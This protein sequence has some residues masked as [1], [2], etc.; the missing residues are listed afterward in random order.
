MNYDDWKTE[1]PEDYEWRIWQTQRRNEYEP[2]GAESGFC[3]CGVTTERAV[4]TR[5]GH[6]WQCKPC[7]EAEIRSI[8]D[9]ASRKVAG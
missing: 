6:R 4:S 1:A 5:S 9:R 8:Y 7:A 2:V 3:E